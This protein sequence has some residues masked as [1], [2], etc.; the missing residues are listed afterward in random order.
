MPLPAS[1]G[2]TIDALLSSP[3][4]CLKLGG[5]ISNYWAAEAQRLLRAA[6]QTWFDVIVVGEAGK[7]HLEL[8]DYLR[9]NL[10]GVPQDPTG[11]TYAKKILKSESPVDWKQPARAIHDKIRAFALGPG[12]TATVNGKKLKLHRARVGGE[13]G[14]P[15]EVLR[16]EAGALVIGTG[17]GS[18]ELIEV[19]PESRQ[20]MK[21]ADFLQGHPLTKGARIE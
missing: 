20:R 14:A 10:A 13:S 16:A 12:V 9:G 2:P 3:T 5:E 21:V 1:L 4:T 7:L 6:Y 17:H 19:Q 8:M 11:V 15:G 18:L